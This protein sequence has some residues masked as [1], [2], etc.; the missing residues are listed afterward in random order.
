MDK[1]K[2]LIVRITAEQ[3]EI[4]HAKARSN[5]FLKK[6]EYVRSVLFRS[7]SVEDKITKIFDKVCKDG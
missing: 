3:D 2:T 5:G 6:S 7:L 4:L 1:I